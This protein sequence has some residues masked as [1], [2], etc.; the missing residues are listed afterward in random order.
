VA[1]YR[2]ALGRK[3]RPSNPAL[4]VLAACR[5]AERITLS[6]E[7]NDVDAMKRLVRGLQGRGATVLPVSFHSSSLWPGHNPYVRDKSE[8]HRF[9]DRLSEILGHLSEQ[10]ECHFVGAPEL[11]GLFAIPWSAGP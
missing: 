3:Q 2:A 6:P 10:A 8:L 7:G 11:P 4:G 9:Y 5:I 1:L